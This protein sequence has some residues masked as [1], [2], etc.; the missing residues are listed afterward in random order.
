MKN[1]KVIDLLIQNP[2]AQFECLEK[3][4]DTFSQSETCLS[5]YIRGSLANK[6]YDRASDVDLMVAVEPSHYAKTVEALN[7]IVGDQLSL[8]FPGWYDKIVPDFGGLGFVYLVNWKGT[9]LQAD[10]YIL[11]ADRT[12]LIKKAP[13]AQ[14]VYSRGSAKT[15]SGA[16]V[17]ELIISKKDT[18]QTIQQI[19][20]EIFILAALIHKRIRRHQ[21][22]LNYSET[23]ML[24]TSVRNLMRTLW[25]PSHIAFGWYSFAENCTFANQSSEWMQKFEEIIKARSLHDFASL[26]KY[27]DFVLQFAKENCPEDLKPLQPG[28]DFMMSVFTG[29]P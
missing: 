2:P 5:A 6:N 9:Y 14:Q 7:V 10:V 27:L 28:I 3:L 16:E 4:I 24:N 22:Y 1:Q 19:I 29:R 11:P 18:V 25:D 13:R 26:N 17:E 15:T 23:Y 21:I 8:I 20:I 12:E